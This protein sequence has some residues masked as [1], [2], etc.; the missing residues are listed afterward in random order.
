[1]VVLAIPVINRQDLLAKCLQ[2]IDTEV[3]LIVIDNSFSGFAAATVVEH[4]EG[5]FFVTEPPAN[6]GYAG[7]V[8]HIIQTRPA[9]PFWLFAN[10]DTEFGAGDLQRLIEEMDKGGPRWVGVTDWRV[11]GLTAEAV[12]LAGFWDPNF[13]PAFVEDCDYERRCD[14]AGVTRYFID[15][16][17]THVRSVSIGEERNARSNAKTYPANL[18]YYAEKW[19]GPPRGGERF[20]TPYNRGGSIRD[21]T[22]SRRR[23]ADQQWL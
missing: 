21:W 1:M 5:E 22:L 4:Y 10:A 9:E 17:T 20:S 3:D 6:L 14:L 7:S 12:D 23:L 18:A 19:G 13:H 15:G 2:S 16:T 8:N 11:F